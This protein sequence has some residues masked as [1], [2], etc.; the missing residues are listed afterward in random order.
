MKRDGK[1]STTPDS[2]GLAGAGITEA[3][4]RKATR[5]GWGEWYELLDAAGAREMTH[6]LI[7]AVVARHETSAWWQQMITVAY[8]QARGLREKH[9][10]DDGF[11]ANASKIILA[12]ITRVYSA[13]TDD[14]TRA[15]WLDS[16]G[17]HIRKTVPY[18]SLRATWTDG[19]THVEVHLWPRAEGKTLVQVEHHR[20]GNTE[21]VHRAKA[22]WS[23]A[24]ERL[25]GL[26]ETAHE[27][28]SLA[29]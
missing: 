5:R 3:A 27:P 7:V 13:W 19:R 20:L 12:G 23:L 2:S 6:P 26:L 16:T 11:A 15:A 14:D 17:W 8:E 24:L 28:H 29:A 1:G 18:K 21:E 25:R 4:V 9:Q 22:F 10:R